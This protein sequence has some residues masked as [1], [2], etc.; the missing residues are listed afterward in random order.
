MLYKS[1]F[2][3]KSFWEF[4]SKNFQIFVSFI[5]DMMGWIYIPGLEL[6]WDKNGPDKEPLCQL[7]CRGTMAGWLAARFAGLTRTAALQADNQGE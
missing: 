7:P 4:L 2:G 1:V 5:R 3:E 6:I